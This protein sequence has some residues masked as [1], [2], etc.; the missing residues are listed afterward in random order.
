MVLE[1]ASTAVNKHGIHVFSDFDGTITLA[2]TG[3]ILIDHCVGRE[4]RRQMDLDVLN[5]KTSF[6]ELCVQLWGGVNL[7]WDQAIQMLED[8]QVDPHFGKCLERCR[9]HDIPF[10]VLSCGLRA[11]IEWYL[12][13]EIG[14]DFHGIEVLANEADY[15]PAGW[16][17]TFHDASPHGHDKAV[18]IRRAREAAKANSQPFLAI[19]LGD[20]ISDLSAAMEA[21]ILFAR[22]GR[23]L[24]TYCTR[25]GIDHIAFD[26]FDTAIAE[27]EK[28]QQQ[29]QQ[30]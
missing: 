22:R 30:Q 4:R 8:V 11:L 6:R 17:C 2:D 15:N 25:E 7:D 14:S 9:A 29:Q 24:E 5:G 3:V 28:L 18:S 12:K 20:G 26:T 1:P 21:D 16:T 13:R 10:T 23:D 19:F 27:I